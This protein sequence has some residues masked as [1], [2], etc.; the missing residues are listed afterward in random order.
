M[1]MKSLGKLSVS[2]RALLAFVFKNSLYSGVFA[3]V[4]GLVIVPLVSAVTKGSCPANVDE[5]F[6]C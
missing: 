1:D 5:I 3:M 2:G 4:G 6:R